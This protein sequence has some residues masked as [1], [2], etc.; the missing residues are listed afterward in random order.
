[1]R[2]MHML[3]P[4]RNIFFFEKKEFLLYPGGEG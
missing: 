1:M 4:R 3:D 2:A